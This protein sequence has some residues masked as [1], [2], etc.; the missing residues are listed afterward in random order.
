MHKG[1]VM[2][3]M[4]S[5]II[6]IRSEHIQPLL[7]KLMDLN[8]LNLN[9][10]I[11]TSKVEEVFLNTSKDIINLSLNKVTHNKVTHNKVTH[12]REVSNNSEVPSMS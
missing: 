11:L 1:T 10:L 2:I 3:L 8:I 12:S 7:L 9:I 4:G 5:P 6:C